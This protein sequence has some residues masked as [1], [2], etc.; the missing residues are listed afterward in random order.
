MLGGVRGAGGR[1]RLQSYRRHWRPHRAEP[2]A[3]LTS[4]DAGAAA[5]LT[6][7]C[8]LPLT[9]VALVRGHGWSL[10]QRGGVV[11]FSLRAAAAKLLSCAVE[12]PPS[13]PALCLQSLVFLLAVAT[14]LRAFALHDYQRQLAVLA[15]SRAPAAAAAIATAARAPPC[16]NCSWAL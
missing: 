15:V 1:R 12:L 2:S 11:L 13:S 9:L 5:F 10:G 14:C 8:I 7:S 3:L 6:L 16:R 4:I